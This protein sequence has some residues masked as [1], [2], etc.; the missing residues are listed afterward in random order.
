MLT[1]LCRTD[2][3]VSRSAAVGIHL[4]PPYPKRLSIMACLRPAD[5]SSQVALDR[6]WHGKHSARADILCPERRHVHL[7]LRARRLGDS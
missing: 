4:C 7:E 2:I 1:R 6:S 5:D 3:L